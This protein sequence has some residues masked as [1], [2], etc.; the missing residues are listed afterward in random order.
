MGC[1]NPTL[2]STRCLVEYLSVWFFILNSQLLR[3]G[4]PSI[5]ILINWYHS[6]LSNV[7]ERATYEGF[8]PMR[9]LSEVLQSES[10]DMLTLTGGAVIGTRV[11]KV[12]KSHIEQYMGCSVKYLSVWF[13]PFNASL[14]RVGS[15]S[16]WALIMFQ[17][18]LSKVFQRQI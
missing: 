5:W 4:S 2:S 17:L 18:Y 12:P 15:R 8:W 9:E 1:P 16:A 7:S 6:W 10:L 14:L 11:Y 13:S 3:V